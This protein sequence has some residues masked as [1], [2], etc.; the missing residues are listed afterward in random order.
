MFV[1][2]YGIGTDYILF[3]LFR[4][5]ER[6][7]HGEGTAEG[8]RVRPRAGRRGDRSRPAARTASFLALVCLS[9]GMVRTIGP[10]LAIAVAVT[11]VAALTLVPP[12]SRFGR[13]LFCCRRST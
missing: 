1:V 9:L 10:A 4:Y 2:L 5:R 11:L 13:A 12:S 6:L 3:F 7:R 8:G